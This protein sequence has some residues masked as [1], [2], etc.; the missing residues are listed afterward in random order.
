[1]QVSS[2]AAMHD[3][4]NPLMNETYGQKIRPAMAA[5]TGQPVEI[6]KY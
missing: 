3:C 1:M 6:S 5:S 4:E 2:L